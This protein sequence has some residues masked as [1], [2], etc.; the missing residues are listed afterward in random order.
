[1]TRTQPPQRYAGRLVPELD[2]PL[3]PWELDYFYREIPERVERAE[4]L[5]YR[6][7]DEYSTEFRDRRNGRF[8][9][10]HE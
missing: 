2:P 1:M 10:R 7:P 6:M 8:G 5:R 3:E 9:A 4:Q